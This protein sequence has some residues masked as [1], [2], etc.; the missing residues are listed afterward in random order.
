MMNFGSNEALDPIS[1][2]TASLAQRER[3]RFR[4]ERDARFAKQDAKEAA[5]RAAVAK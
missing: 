3:E 1:P 5:A 4:V 2:R